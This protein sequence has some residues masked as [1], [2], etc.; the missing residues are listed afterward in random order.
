MGVLVVFLKFPWSSQL[1]QSRECYFI[2]PHY[3]PSTPLPKCSV[4]MLAFFEFRAQEPDPAPSFRLPLPLLLTNLKDTIEDLGYFF[5]SSGKLYVWREISHWGR[6]YIN[7]QSTQLSHVTERYSGFHC[8]GLP[9]LLCKRRN[10]S[11]QG[12]CWRR[13]LQVSP[14]FQIVILVD[15]QWVTN[16]LFFFKLCS[17]F[18]C[19]TVFW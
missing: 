17:L 12:I 6:T 2:G 13:Y 18:P 7:I 1:Y 5:Q 8:P 15:N 14:W 4:K 16:Y 9:S 19:I 3:G 11:K 10:T